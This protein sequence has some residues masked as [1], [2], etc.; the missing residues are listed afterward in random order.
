MA[1]A[2]WVQTLL[3]IHRDKMKNGIFLVAED[4]GS[5]IGITF[6]G[7]KLTYRNG[8]V[9]SKTLNMNTSGWGDIDLLWIEHNDICSH[10]SYQEIVAR[11]I[12]Q[13]LEELP[14]WDEVYFPGISDTSAL[15]KVLKEIYG[16]SGNL[17]IEKRHPD[18]V[19]DLEK[20]RNNG[21]DYLAMLGN[22]TRYNVKKSIKK[23]EDIGTVSVSEAK[24]EQE[25]LIWMRNMKQYSIN[26]MKK[27]KKVSSFENNNFTSFHE[28]YFK[29]SFPSGRVL[30]QKFSVGDTVIGYHYHI[31]SNRRLYFYQCGYDYDHLEN[32]SPGIFCHYQNILWAAS[33]GFLIYD[34][35]PGEAMYKKDL[36]NSHVSE[37][38]EWLILRRPKIKFRI[39]N[40]CRIVRDQFR[41][42][43]ARFPRKEKNRV[44][45]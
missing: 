43:I 10:G 14:F 19:I 1:S 2:E 28:E 8:F 35:M 20:I 6:F 23:F 7:K 37:H 29:R 25:S 16:V 42:I 15:S 12:V 26:R 36:S 40:R 5:P 44:R 45:L 3:N 41:E 32:V 30:M 38:V 11:K 34:F 22:S 33:R 39:E 21:N 27:L 24:S 17:L 13:A 9:L 31:L 4:N 18:Y